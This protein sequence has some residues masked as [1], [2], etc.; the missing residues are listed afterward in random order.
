MVVRGVLSL[1]RGRF[2]SRD[3]TLEGR[4]RLGTA[5]PP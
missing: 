4:T 5:E 1:G 3:W 2:S